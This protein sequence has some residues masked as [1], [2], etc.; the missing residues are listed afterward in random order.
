MRCSE[1]LNG[2]DSGPT[3]RAWNPPRLGRFPA[4]GGPFNVANKRRPRPGDFLVPTGD[5][6]ISRAPPPRPRRRRQRPR[7]LPLASGG[8]GGCLSKPPGAAFS[9]CHSPPLLGLVGL[10]IPTDLSFSSRTHLVVDLLGVVA[11]RASF[12]ASPRMRASCCGFGRQIWD[13]AGLEKQ[14]QR[15]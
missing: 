7:R 12:R 1:V 13:A 10:R 2:L 14:A 4:H 8:D 15:T 3:S 6:S 5:S 9:P 11:F